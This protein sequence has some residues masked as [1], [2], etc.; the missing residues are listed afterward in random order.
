LIDF[1]HRMTPVAYPTYTLTNHA[2]PYL[3][4]RHQRR[5]RHYLPGQVR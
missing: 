2:V 4:I 5:C 3:D 1:D